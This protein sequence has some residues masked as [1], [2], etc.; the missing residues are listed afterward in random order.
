MRSDRDSVDN[1]KDVK[2][3]QNRFG[4]RADDG[5]DSRPEKQQPSLRRMATEDSGA[6]PS[7]CIH[8][9]DMKTRSTYEVR[10][11][12]HGAKYQQRFMETDTESGAK[13][14]TTKPE[15]MPS[16]LTFTPDEIVPDGAAPKLTDKGHSAV[17]GAKVKAAANR[18][19]APAHSLPSPATKKRLHFE[20][21]HPADLAKRKDSISHAPAAA[22]A[23]LARLHSNVRRADDDNNIGVRAANET[24]AAVEGAG[25]TALRARRKTAVRKTVKASPKPRTVPYLPFSS[26]RKGSKAQTAKAAQKRMVKKSHAKA[27][28]ANGRAS[29]AMRRAANGAKQAAMRTLHAIKI[30]PAAIAVIAVL[31]ILVLVIFSAFSSCS[32]I[33]LGSVGSI[34]VSSYLAGDEAIDDAELLYTEWETDLLIEVNDAERTHPGYDEY[35][36]SIGDISHSPFELMAFLTAVYQNFA[37]AEANAALKEA[38]GRQYR[39]EYVPETET[40]QRTEMRTDPVT[41]EKREVTV[42]YEWRIINVRLTANSFSD[43]A[44]SLMDEQERERYGVLLM[45]RGNRQYVSNIFESEWLSRISSYYGYRLHPISGVKDYHK[46]IDIAFPSGTKIRAGHDGTVRTAGES[47]SYGLMAVIDGSL[48]DGSVL[49]TRY[50]HCSRL[51]VRAGQQVK[52]GDVIAEVGSTGNSTGPHLHFEIL[53]NGRNLNPIYFAE[54]GALPGAGSIPGG[55]GGP[56]IPLYPGAPMDDARFEAMIRE[57]QKH[58]GKPYVF[59]ASGPSSFDCSGF[60]CFVLNNSGARSVGRTTAQGLYNMT[61]TVSQEN[62][63]PGDLI[64]FTRTYSAGT[65]V[66]HVGIYLGNGKMIHAG[67]PV[68]YADINASYWRQ[69]FYAFGRI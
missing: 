17:S 57:A 32:N 15:A 16:K 37:P 49:T 7:L 3:E 47:G 10:L 28:R 44:Y 69:H 25:R 21:E 63:K 13:G 24:M 29:P 45:S 36:Y 60:V 34:F 50:A 68:Q 41:G 64:F 14:A 22:N 56:D 18:K 62:A 53:V 35:R 67:D 52:A 46:G 55:S 20:G 43:I 2:P 65:P 51:L 19:A 4:L 40:R 6:A 12:Q 26:S 27:A 11:R 23:A 38:F 5:A 9:G 61:T 1:D 58:L 48:P 31:M 8:D 66:T 54:T 59:G 30:H 39:L 42:S 33:S